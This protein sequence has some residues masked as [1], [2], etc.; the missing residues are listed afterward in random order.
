[1]RGPLDLKKRE[2]LVQI[3]IHLEFIDIFSKGQRYV[4]SKIAIFLVHKTACNNFVSHFVL[5]LF[6][7][8]IF[9]AQLTKRQVL[10]NLL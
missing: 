7:F 8:L 4:P 10:V 6:N 1:M 9:N 3:L 2:K 5:L